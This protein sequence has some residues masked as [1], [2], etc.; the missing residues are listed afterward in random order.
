MKVGSEISIDLITRLPKSK[1]QNDSIMVVDK[2]S[3]APRF[4]PVKSTYKEINI[5][6]IFM[7][8]VFRLHGIPKIIVL[9][10]DVKF[11]RNFW[12]SLFRGLNTKLNFST[13]YH[14]QADG[15]TERVN[16]V[17][18][19]MLRMYVMDKPSNWE[20][21]LHLVEFSYNNH[22]HASAKMSP[23]EILYGRRCNTPISWSKLVD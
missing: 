23:F 15:Q 10:S 21:F 22:Y 14:P 7:K 6:N 11:T 13:T 19:D 5:A 3:K 4:I 17:L 2:L 12:K 20:D 18:E 16:Q 8:E 9:D 1:R